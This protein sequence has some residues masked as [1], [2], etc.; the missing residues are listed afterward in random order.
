MALA[1]KNKTLPAIKDQLT[2]RSIVG[3]KK[4]VKYD[5][6]RSILTGHELQNLYD[7]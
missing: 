5:I 2:Y 1:Q 7:Y 6:I 3:L 4:L